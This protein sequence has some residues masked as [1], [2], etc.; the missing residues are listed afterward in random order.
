MNTIVIAFYIL[1]FLVSI[2]VGFILYKNLKTKNE[3]LKLIIPV[4]IALGIAAV[5][6]LAGLQV[7]RTSF[8]R[9][10]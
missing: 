1:S 5:C 8:G 4:L 6:Y 3:R 10:I 2:F 9:F 7:P